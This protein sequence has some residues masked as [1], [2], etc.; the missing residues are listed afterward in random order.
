M[1]TDKLLER[2]E[3][4]FSEKKSQQRKRVDS[5]K[6]LLA[7]LKKKKRKLNAKLKDTDKRS[8]REH[9]RKELEV[10]RVQRRKGLRILKDIK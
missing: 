9:I 5:L 2:T 10:I 3:E 8:D 6:E 4:F 1:K 7:A